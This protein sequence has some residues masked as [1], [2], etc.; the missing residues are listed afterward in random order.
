M[1]IA[2][3]A[4]YPP[5]GSRRFHLL[6]S[7]LVILLFITLQCGYSNPLSYYLSFSFQGPGSVLFQVLCKPS[8]SGDSDWSLLAGGWSDAQGIYQQSEPLW[9]LQEL[10]FCRLLT[11]CMIFADHIPKKKQRPFF[12]VLTFIFTEARVGMLAASLARCWT[13]I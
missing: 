13:E 1:C 9:S 10:S 4:L 7:V 12:E 11:C 2:A 6:Y 5:E 3:A 8:D